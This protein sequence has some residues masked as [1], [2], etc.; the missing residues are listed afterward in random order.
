MLPAQRVSTLLGVLLLLHVWIVFI[1]DGLKPNKASACAGGCCGL[2]FRLVCAFQ[3]VT[4]ILL[5]MIEKLAIVIT[6][7]QPVIKIYRLNT[8]FCGQTLCG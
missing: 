8:R 4:Q 6:F 2:S 5:S 1:F 3:G 7:V